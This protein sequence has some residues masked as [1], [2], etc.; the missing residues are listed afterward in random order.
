MPIVYPAPFGVVLTFLGC[1]LSIE[2]VHPLLISHPLKSMT[3]APHERLTREPLKVRRNVRRLSDY[4]L[5]TIATVL[6]CFACELNDVRLKQLYSA[7]VRT[8]RAIAQEAANRGEP[9][10]AD[11]A[12]FLDEER[13][14][15]DILSDVMLRRGV[16]HG[17]VIR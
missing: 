17:E 3:T 10:T 5:K 7:S 4:N 1:R 16:S 9:L 15:Q 6:D 2:R 13:L 8:S 14:K 12:Q 11:A